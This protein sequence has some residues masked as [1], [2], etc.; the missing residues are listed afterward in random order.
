MTTGRLTR[1][2]SAAA[3]TLMVGCAVSL[4]GLMLWK[5]LRGS[6]R[7]T[8][9]AQFETQ[10]DWQDYAVGGHRIGPANADVLLVEFADFQCP[11]CRELAG[12][13]QASAKR[14]PGRVGI[15]FRHFPLP[16]HRFAMEAAIAS[17]CAARQNRFAELHDKLFEAADSIGIRTWSSF[18]SSAGVPDVTEFERCR[19]DSSATSV[20]RHDIDA[21]KKLGLH[22][23]PTVLMNGVRFSGA[24]PQKVLDSLV[25]VAIKEP[26]RGRLTSR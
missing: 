10:P 4:T 26:R 11:A 22:G 20:V 19:T 6:R 23:T 18:A 8:V 2:A 13:L 15:V 14:L 5:E 24:V 1:L 21:A 9:A 25:D 16:M 3:T 7:P 12:R 17:E